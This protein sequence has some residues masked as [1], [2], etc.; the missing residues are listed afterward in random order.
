MR[1]TDWL[2]RL[3]PLPVSRRLRQIK[4][5]DHSFF[6]TWAGVL[7]AS[8]IGPAGKGR[9]IVSSNRFATMCQVQYLPS[10]GRTHDSLKDRHDLRNYK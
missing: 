6:D 5:A 9:L 4:F 1:T 10:I 2:F 8:C 3:D 7:P